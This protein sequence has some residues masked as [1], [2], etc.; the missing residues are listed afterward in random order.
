M[1]LSNPRHYRKIDDGIRSF[2]FTFDFT[3]DFKVALV[4]L[5]SAIGTLTFPEIP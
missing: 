4:A 1:K 5:M 2:D 3:F